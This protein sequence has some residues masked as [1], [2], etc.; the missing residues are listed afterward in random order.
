MS[1]SANA[2]KS[3]A[4][5]AIAAALVRLQPGETLMYAQ[6]H[7]MM[8]GDRN[9]LARAR[10]QAERSHGYIFES[11]R[12]IGVK[13]LSKVKVIV[14]EAMTKAARVIDRA[15]DRTVNAMIRD[16]SRMT[17][18]EKVELNSGIAQINA[19]QLAIK[20]AKG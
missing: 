13:R 11:V 1:R 7:N 8:M 3:E 12:G 2:E 17:R 6:I 10:K 14:D 4:V 15:E 19:V 9:L 5:D 20:L 18:E 16:G